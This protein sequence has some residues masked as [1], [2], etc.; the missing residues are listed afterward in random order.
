M[1]FN[2]FIYLSINLFILGPHVWEVPR[3]GVELELQLPDYATTIAMKDLSLVCDLHR[4]S[5]QCRTLNPLNRA[6]DRTCI[7]KDNSQVCYC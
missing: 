3:L 2:L 4:S 5:Q 7:L 6:R 1:Y